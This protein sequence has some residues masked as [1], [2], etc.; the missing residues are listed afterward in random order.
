ML[1]SVFAVALWCW[2]CV[3]SIAPL[4]IGLWKKRCRQTLYRLLHTISNRLQICWCFGLLLSLWCDAFAI[5]SALFEYLAAN[6]LAGA[7][8][9]L[10]AGSEFKRLPPCFGRQSELH[11][12]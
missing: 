9:E 3:Q 1:P 6:M 10:P 11:G 12:K 7:V 2:C 5:V 4:Y 8:A